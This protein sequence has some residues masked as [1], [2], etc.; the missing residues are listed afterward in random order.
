MLTFLKDIFSENKEDN[1]ELRQEKLLQIAATALFIELAKADNNYSAEEKITVNRI[2]KKMFEL[3][4]EH[5][6]ELIDIAEERI[7][8]SVSLYEFT[9]ILNKELDQDEKYKLSVNMWQIV[10][11]DNTLNKYE[12]YLMR[13]ISNNLKLSHRDMIAAKLEAKNK[14]NN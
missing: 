5:A 6:H 12:E 3:T 10:Y 14:T 2:L 13:I 7:V 1:S 9:E 4:E 11:A 8:K